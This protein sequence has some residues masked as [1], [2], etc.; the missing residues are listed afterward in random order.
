MSTPTANSILMS[1]GGSYASFKSHGDTIT[2]TILDVGE[3][4]HVREYNQTTQRSDG[5]PKYTKAGKPVYA[6]HLTLSTD[7]RKPED[8]DDDGTRVV[9]VNSWRMQDALRNAIRATGAQGLEV[10]ARVTVSYTHDEV[11]GDPRSGKNFTAQYV[12]PTNVA[13]M[14]DDQQSPATAPQQPAPQAPAQQQ[15]P[16]APAA[17]AAPSGEDKATK[18]RQLA[19]LG[20][21]AA[22]IAPQVGLDVDVVQMFL[23][24]AA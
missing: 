10:G 7:E 21:D 19:A 20:M 18:V 22:A 2:G 9:D 17:P 3:P 5:P 24:Q 16:A 4:Y 6:F 15:A 11:P 14:G 8:P 12:R 23:N 13:L 1:G